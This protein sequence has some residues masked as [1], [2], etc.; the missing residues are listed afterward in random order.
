MD[1]VSV[2]EPALMLTPLPEFLADPALRAVLAA[3][4]RARL[5]GGAVRDAVAGRAATDIDLATP[6]PPEAVA[7]C[8]AQA[9]LS[10]VPTGLAHGTLTAVSAG[11]GFEITTLRRDL[12]TDGRHAVIAFTDD[13]AADAARRDFTLN[14][15]S[16]TAEGAVF[17]YTG[18]LADLRAGVVRFVGDPAQ[19][20][21]EDWLRALRFF[22][23]QARYGRV[24]PDAAT[25]A[26]LREAVPR[27][28]GLSA[29][30]VWMEMKRLLATPDPLAALGLMRMLGVLDAI[31]PEL[32]GDTSALAALVARGAPADPLLRLAALLADD[33][34]SPATR[35]RFSRAEAARLAALR[36]APMPPVTADA[37][38]LLPLLADWPADILIGRAWLGGRDGAV[39]DALA[40]LSRPVFPLRGQD[41]QGAGIAPGKA[42][43]EA[44]AAVRAWWLAER[45]VPD[46]AACLARLR[47]FG[48]APTR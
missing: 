34:P 11:R 8:L 5:V 28:A 14:T 2:A 9:G 38:A 15:L 25:L 30:R 43:G 48:P 46:R 16:M 26:A 45:C 17:D 4:P 12:A 37:A 22:R 44:L 36:T 10:A 40:R 27:L 32:S 39:R 29:E 35:L 19:R 6:D 31:L 7:R 20:L 3:L 42:L 41:A 24:P 21:A 33:A 13:W 1:G 47:R 23:F 18:G